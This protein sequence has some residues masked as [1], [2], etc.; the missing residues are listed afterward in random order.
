MQY[1][2]IGI[3]AVSSGLLAMIPGAIAQTVIPTDPT[4][5][6]PTSL[7]TID[8]PFEGRVDRAC[9]FDTPDPG[10]LVPVDL[11]RPQVLSSLEP[12][13]NP[14]Q[15]NLFCNGESD[16]SVNEPVQIGGP[17]VEITGEQAFVTS[18]FGDTASSGTPLTLPSGVVIPLT[19]DMSVRAADASVGFPVGVYRYRVTLVVTP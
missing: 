8:I 16:L 12:G 3:V 2:S 4:P 13:G 17:S 6:E 1:F 5:S 18:P 7:P 15:V 14:G 11:P 10:V 19:I 9:S